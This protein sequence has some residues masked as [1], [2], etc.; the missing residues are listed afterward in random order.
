MKL[1][2]AISE[3]LKLK[4]ISILK[5][6]LVLNL[7]NDYKAFEEYPSS[8]NVLKNIISE[9]LM[10]KILFLHENQLIQQ[11]T[12]ST[13][14][15]ELYEKYGYRKDVSTYVIASLFGALGYEIT[16]PETSENQEEIAT[17]TATL[18]SAKTGNHLTFRDIEINGTVKGFCAELKKLGY[19]DP[20]YLDGGS[21]V[22]KGEFAG[23]KDCEI[24]VLKS[25]YTDIVWKVVVMMSE[26]KS[27]HSLKSDY[28]RFKDM[29]T[30]KY[31]VPQAY[32]YFLDPYY[33]GDG[34]EL[35]ALEMEKCTYLSCFENSLGMIGVSM[36]ASGY[37]SIGYEDGINAKL[38]SDAVN[39]SAFDEI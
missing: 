14:I 13:Y 22:V 32:E 37:V 18:S 35:Q 26:C 29:Y 31:G 33:E 2:E 36:S 19:S 17:I 5:N 15:N 39:S 30:K 23:V 9:E 38:N 6:T 28:E 24:L 3:I 4:D 7:L 8:K 25:R 1:K 16:I 34:Y 10:E 27:W 21:C 11:A 12:S 20:I